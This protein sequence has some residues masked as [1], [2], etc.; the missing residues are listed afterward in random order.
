MPNPQS[1]PINN[2]PSWKASQSMISPPEKSANQWQA[3]ASGRHPNSA[4]SL[5]PP[6]LKVGSCQRPYS[7]E[8]RNTLKVPQCLHTSTSLHPPIPARLALQNL[9]KALALLWKSAPYKYSSPSQVNAKFTWF[10]AD[11]ESN[12]LLVH[13]SQWLTVCYAFDV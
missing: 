8:S 2:K 10:A 12:L 7:S 4:C 3:H 6:V 13:R 1:Q 9:P 5:Q 11:L